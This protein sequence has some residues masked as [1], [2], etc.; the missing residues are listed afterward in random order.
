MKLNIQMFAITNFQQTIWSKKIQTVLE[1]VTGL[2]KH[3]DFQ[4]EGEVK[5][6]KELKILGVTR[7]TIRTY[8]PGTPLNREAGTDSSQLL[9]IDQFRYFDFAVEDI[10][11]AQSVPGLIEA[12]SSE[13]AKGLAESADEYIATLTAD[14]TYTSA[15][16]AIGK[17]TIVAEIE[18]GF[19][20]LYTNNCKPTDTFH[21]EVSPKFYTT[22]RP[23]MT[24]LFTDNVEMSKKGIVGKYG[25]ALVSIENNLYDDETDKWCLLRTSKAIA[26]AGQIDKVEAYRPQDAFTDAVKGLFVFGAKIVRPEQLYVIKAH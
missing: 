3:S 12:L 2:R 18:K 9:K 10:D 13:A 5:M 7:P 11:K 25:N 1:T 26:F 21:L 24:E 20:Q 16:Y 23:A 15:S 17:T 8:V 6:G 4:F 19:E 22:L 14:A